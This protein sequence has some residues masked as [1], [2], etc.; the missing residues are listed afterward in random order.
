MTRSV[1][2]L[3]K[4]GIFGLV[5]AVLTAFLFVVF[6]ES[7][8]GATNGYSAVFA[9]ASRLEAGDSVRIA[10][11]RVGTVKGVSLQADRKVDGRVRRRPQHQADNR[12]QGR[13]P[14]SEPG[15]GPLSGTRRHPGG[16]EDPAGRCTDTGG[17]DSARPGSR[18]VARWPETRYPG[19]ESAGRQRAHHA[20]W[21]RS[22]R[23]R[24]ERWSRCSRRRRRS[25]THSPTTTRSSRD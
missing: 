13:D 7:R 6:G 14:L 19:P 3:I 9:D 1:G 11:I 24:A 5:M 23:G 17:P 25:R 20:L 21:S 10:G 22:C 18:P 8:T 12:H 2:T 15:R 4:F 16:G